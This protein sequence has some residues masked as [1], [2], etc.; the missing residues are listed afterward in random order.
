MTTVY[1]SF[2]QR[3][4]GKKPQVVPQNPKVLA[5]GQPRCGVN[6]RLDEVMYQV[7]NEMGLYEEARYVPALFVTIWWLGEA[8]ETS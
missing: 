1:P 6:V 3:L 4:F 5:P 2:W 7:E 8:L